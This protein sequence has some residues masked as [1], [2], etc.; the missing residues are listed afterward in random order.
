[1]KVLFALTGDTKL[2]QMPV[3]REMAS[4]LKYVIYAAMCQ[5][6]P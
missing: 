4:V 1:M 5:L 3:S 2:S 6:T